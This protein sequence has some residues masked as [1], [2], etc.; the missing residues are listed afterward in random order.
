MRTATVIAL[1]VLVLGAF[2]ASALVIQANLTPNPHF[3]DYVLIRDVA[4]NY[5]ATHHEDA[6]VFM[7]FPG[8]SYLG[9]GTFKSGGWVVVIKGD[10]SNA[11]VTV[12]YSIIYNPNQMG[13]PHRIMWEGTF[14]NGAVQEIGYI[15]AQ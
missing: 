7:G 3:G 9:N 5:I 15:H 13:I 11:S 1:S 4:T 2:F 10:L 14:A 8:W 12:D 6:V